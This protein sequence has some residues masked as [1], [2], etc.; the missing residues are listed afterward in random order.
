[1]YCKICKESGG[2]GIFATSRSPNFK[3]SALQDHTN[4]AEYKRL[5]WVAHSG[6]RRMD[7]IIV[8]ATMTCDEA[9]ITFFIIS[10]YVGIELLPFSK[11]PTLCDFIA[12]SYCHHNYKNVS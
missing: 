8:Q 3:V 10:H 4:T 9:L 7:K 5:S 1:M 2:K 6:S 12:F 11:I